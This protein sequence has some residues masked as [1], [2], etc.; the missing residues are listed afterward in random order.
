M[1]PYTLAYL[2]GHADFAMTKT[3]G[4]PQETIRKAVEN[5]RGGHATKPAQDNP[6][7]S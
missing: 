4:H 7:A 2:A 6:A 3:Y 5:A 1:D